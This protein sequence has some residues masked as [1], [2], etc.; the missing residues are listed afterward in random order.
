MTERKNDQKI[1]LIRIILF[2]MIIFSYQFASAQIRIMPLGDSITSGEGTGQPLTGYR[3]DL[4][5]LLNTEGWE[6]DF[7]GSQSDGSGFDTDHEGHGGWRADEINS[8]VNGWLNQFEPDIVLLHIGTNDV[9]HEQSNSSTANEIESIL[10]KIYNYS[11]KTVILLCKLIPRVNLYQENEDLN[12]LIE[13][14]YQQKKSAGYNIYLVDQNAAFKENPNWEQ[15][16]LH[17]N[18]H[19]AHVGYTVMANKFL[20][21]LET[22]KFWLNISINPSGAG[23]VQLDPDKTKFSYDEHVI[24][25]A[26]ASGSGEFEF[27]SGDVTQDNENPKRIRMWK[28]RNITANFTGAG[29]ETVSTPDKP[30][31]PSSGQK[32]SS[33]SYSTDG[34]TSS[35]GHTVEYRF[36]WGDGEESSWGEATRSHSYSSEGTYYVKARARCV[37]HTNIISNWSSSRSV[38]INSE[39]EV[40]TTPDK[41]SGS[42]S[43]LVGQNLSYSTGGSTS[44]KGNEVEYQFSWGDGN[45]SGWGSASRSHSF[46][47][48]GTYEIRAR[49][50]SKPNPD[51]ESGLS[52]SRNVTI[53]EAV[54]THSLT[55]SVSP[56]GA[57]RIDKTPDKNEFEDDEVVELRARPTDE[58]YQFHHWSGHLSGNENPI[59]ITMDSDKNVTAHFTIETVTVPNI[60]KGFTEGIAGSE[61]EFTVD[62]AQSSFDHSVEYQFDFGDGNLSD[63]GTASVDYAFTNIGSFEV[64][65]RARCS[66]HPTIISEWSD[67]FTLTIQGLILTIQVIPDTAGSVSMDPEK[68]AYNYSESVELTAIPTDGSFS[69]DFWSGDIQDNS[70][71]PRG[72][73]MKRDRTITA[74][75]ISETVSVP[76]VP[77]GQVQGSLGQEM[78]FTSGGSVSSF[79]HEV[80]YQFDWGDSTFSDWGFSSQIH[81]FQT[82]GTMKIRVRARCK[83][84]NHV[85]SDWSETLIIDIADFALNITIEP[86]GSGSVIKN[87]DKGKYN[88]GEI[89]ELSPQGAPG[90][91]FDFWTGDLVGTSNPDTITINEDKNLTAHFLLTHEIVSTPNIPTGPEMGILGRALSFNTGGSASNFGN[92]IE[93]KFDWGDSSNSVW[94]D[95]V[96]AHRYFSTGEK[97]VKAIARS[98][99]DTTIFSEWSDVQF[100]TINGHTL[101]VLVDPESSGEVIITP[102]LSEYA[103]SVVVQLFVTPDSGYGFTHWSGDNTGKQNPEIIII[104]NNMSMTAHLELRSEEVTPPHTLIVPENPAIGDN[105]TFFAEGAI[106]NYGFEVEYQFDW[107]DSTVSTWGSN[108][109]SHIYF[110]SDSLEVKARAR[111][112]VHPHIISN[113]SDPQT[114]VLIGYHL[115]ILIEPE[116]KGLIASN[117]NKIEYSSLDTVKLWAVGINGYKFDSWSGD[118]ISK[119]NPGIVTMNSDKQVYA[120]FIAEV[121]T[122]RAPLSPQGRVSGYRGQ[123]LSYSSVVQQSNYAGKLT[124]QFNWGDGTVSDWGDSSQ[125]HIY[126]ASGSFSLFSRA[127][128]ISD[129]TEISPWS[130]TTK[131]KIMGCKLI[132]NLQPGNAGIVSIQPREDDYDFDASVTL[133]AINYPYFQFAYWNENVNDTASTKIVSIKGDTIMNA[134]FVPALTVKNTTEGT[135]KNFILRQNYPNPFNPETRIEYQLAKDCY[136]RMIIYNVKSQVIKVLVDEEQSAGMYSIMWNALNQQGTKVPSGVYL[137][138]IKTEYYEQVRKMIL[139]K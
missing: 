2:T 35:L 119:T 73:Y 102:N 105:L 56:E 95:R 138:H 81:S 120:H 112:K 82:N 37:T 58:S 85:V 52:D 55:V 72:I 107:G 32:N 104:V 20:S 87:P 10:S 111:S 135:P 133:W 110:I 103:D 83:E 65:A 64:Q 108:E 48:S 113:W 34:A 28:S 84:H 86:A 1:F 6:F 77:T 16:Y 71:N 115:T 126:L 128:C 43:G 91:S 134:L 22:V 36:S 98:K 59:D 67:K 25:T 70:N 78:T 92:E 57:G 14:V 139:M 49:A 5:T 51:V 80:E 99:S 33:L 18:V 118:I 13:Q 117:P 136:V 79:D 54:G 66:S 129:T 76:N 4:F 97:Q 41:P 101:S 40:V 27:W 17:D 89:V 12:E 137:Y 122:L 9:S 106:N 63:W 60:P 31:G 7:V 121:E 26:Q 53:N 62:G 24:L 124:F 39:S 132:V 8:N 125:T 100:V 61:L 90:Y 23:S 69:F 116:G 130:D 11:S 15:D 96:L 3:D 47:S 19:P 75:F 68:D 93:Y 45:S 127:R 29:T 114:I 38:T 44:S 46:G 131:V 50:R 30:S 109:R 94:G 123:S 74:N 88:D 21:V 42:S